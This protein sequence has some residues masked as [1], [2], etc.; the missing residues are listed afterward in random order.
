LAVLLYFDGLCGPRNPGG[1]AIYGFV[2]Y[3]D[4]EK[5]KEDAGLACEPWTPSASNNVAEYRGLIEGLKWLNGKGMYREVEVRG[6]SML[7]IRQMKGEYRVR[8]ERIRPLHSE[9]ERLSAKFLGIRIVWIPRE[10]N[11]ADDLCKKA[12]AR[13]GV[14]ESPREPALIWRH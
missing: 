12:Y 1:V 8:A 4:A 7:V 9:A 3:R 11:E 14:G 13:Y 6:D 10:Q 2:I 5:L